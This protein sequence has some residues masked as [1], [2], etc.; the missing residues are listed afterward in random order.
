M[1]QNKSSCL[2]F[3]HA[4]MQMCSFKET[5]PQKAQEIMNFYL[6]NTRTILI[7][8]VKCWKKIKKAHT[9]PAFLASYSSFDEILKITSCGI[10]RDLLLL[11]EWVL[12]HSQ[13]IPQLNPLTVAPEFLKSLSTYF[14]FFLFL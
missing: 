2:T 12:D 6:L 8:F 11:G 5:D 1:R 13:L 9:W 3:I 14:F 10:S 7:C 4:C